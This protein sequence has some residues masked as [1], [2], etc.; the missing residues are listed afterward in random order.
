MA[1]VPHLVSNP[2]MAKAFA[3]PRKGTVVFK[4]RNPL[5]APRWV[6]LQWVCWLVFMVTIIETYANLAA[7]PEISLLRWLTSSSTH[8]ILRP[9]QYREATAYQFLLDGLDGEEGDADDM[10]YR[11]DLRFVNTPTRSR[12]Q[13]QLP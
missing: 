1:I 5:A 13:L 4:T 2:I 9:G 8:A 12:F 6:W 11:H 7:H 3:L 10:G